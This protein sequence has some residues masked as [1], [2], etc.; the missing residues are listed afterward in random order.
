MLYAISLGSMGER[1][2]APATTSTR[3]VEHV[4]DALQ[5]WEMRT[6]MPSAA[7]S[8]VDPTGT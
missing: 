8:T 4:P 7:S 2:S 6:P 3:Q 5:T 1:F